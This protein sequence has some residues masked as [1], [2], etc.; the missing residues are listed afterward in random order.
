MHVE[1]ADP[2]PLIPQAM[3]SPLPEA[4][5]KIEDAIVPIDD[6]PTTLMQW[7]V[8]ILNTPNPT[9]KA[10]LHKLHIESPFI[11]PHLYDRSSVL[12]KLF[13]FSVQANWYPSAINHRMLPLPQMFLPAKKDIPKT[14]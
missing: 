5:T 2:P 14:P 6:A 10:R 4:S 3:N 7:A 9:L 1:F 8:L 12:A 11:S 13:T